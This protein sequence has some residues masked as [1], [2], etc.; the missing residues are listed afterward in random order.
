MHKAFVI[1]PITKLIH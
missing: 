1:P